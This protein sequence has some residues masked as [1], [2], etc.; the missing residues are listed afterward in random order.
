MPSGGC[1]T[2]TKGGLAARHRPLG[3]G[4]QDSSLAPI[5]VQLQ[6][7]QASPAAVNQ[8]APPY[9]PYRDRLRPLTP[10]A[11]AHLSSLRWLLWGLPGCNAGKPPPFCLPSPWPPFCGG[12]LA[13]TATDSRRWH[14]YPVCVLSAQG[15]F[16]ACL[17]E[18][19]ANTPNLLPR[20][21]LSSWKPD[22]HSG[23]D[24][25]GPRLQHTGYIPSPQARQPTP[26]ERSQSQHLI[27]AI[28]G[29]NTGKQKT[30]YA[31]ISWPGSGGCFY[32]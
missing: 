24:S 15:A 17:V 18:P 3:L 19:A 28:P 27:P 7:E 11:K 6:C 5:L 23:A 32:F 20:Y 2:F 26:W 31:T 25:L 14:L 4:L 29:Q 21:L 16:G 10:G 30:R 9:Y 22:S 13:L 8:A 1:G 12:Y